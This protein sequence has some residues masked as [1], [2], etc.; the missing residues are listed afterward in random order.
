MKENVV[1][2]K[3]SV[4][5]KYTLNMEQKRVD[6][7]MDYKGNLTIAGRVDN[8]YLFWLSESKI[9]DN[10]ENARFFQE[11]TSMKVE[12]VA[13]SYSLEKSYGGTFKSSLV[14]TS[15]NDNLKWRT[16]FGYYYGRDETHH[17]ESFARDIQHYFKEQKEKCQLREIGGHFYSILLEYSKILADPGLVYERIR[18]LQEVI[19]LDSF[20]L[21]SDNV[22]LRNLY[23]SCDERIR[24]LYC[25]Y[26]T[27]VR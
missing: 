1:N 26:M 24:N 16:P 12:K 11:I 10:Q 21:L 18:N 5:P 22:K 7:Y 8:N 13:S 3:N 9:E 2:S 25:D 19:E 27:R 17:G 4:V 15:T 14:L 20:L 6:C 23:M